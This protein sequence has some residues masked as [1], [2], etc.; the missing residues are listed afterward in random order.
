MAT[1]SADEICAQV[2]AIH[3]AYRGKLR[4]LLIEETGAAYDLV[5]K[6]AFFIGIMSALFYQAMDMF[7]MEVRMTK[8]LG[9]ADPREA[10]LAFVGDCW[11]D[12]HDAVQSH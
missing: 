8:G 11:D 4:E 1:I 9:P 10:F 5:E 7:E 6:D 3:R 2:Q 12:A